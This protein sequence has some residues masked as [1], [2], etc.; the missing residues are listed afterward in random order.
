MWILPFSLIAIPV[1]LAIPLSAYLAWIMGGHYRPKGF[2]RWCEDR[3][4]SG[5]QNWKQYAVSLLAFNLVLYVF[6]FLILILQP[7]MPLNPRGLGAL[8]PSTIL[9]TVMS[10]ITN[11][12]I[13][14]YSGDVAF[15]N[16][17]QL[18][19]CLPMFFLSASVGFCALTAMIRA[20]RSDPDVGNF[21]LDM[22]R[23]VFY[24]FLPIAFVLS[25][26]YL[27]SGMPMTYQSDY[28]V[29]TLEPTAMGTT[30]SGQPKQQTIVVGPLAAFVPMKM[31]G[32]NGGGFYGMNSAHPF[33]NPSAF[34]N[35]LTTSSMMLFP[36]ALVFMYGRMLRRQRHG[37]VIFSVMLVLLVGTVLWAIHFDTLK[38][39]PGLSADPIARTFEIPS[40]SAPGGKRVIS[41]PAVAGLPVD[42][43]LGN[44]EGKELRFGTSAGSTFAAATVD[45]TCGA[46]NCEHDS[47]N[48]V[49]AV[50]PFFGM[51]VNCIFGGKGVGMINFLL[52]LIIGIF[53]VGQMV[54]RT[55]E[56]L[57]K[58]IGARE[59][60][61]AMIAL[62]IH[63]LVILGPSGLFAATNWGIK[64]ESNPGAHGFSQ[65]VY[66]F[67]SDSAN[68]GS[69]FDGLGTTYGLNNN[70]NPAPEAVPW[71][72]AATLVIM[73]GRFIPI[74]APIA[75]AGFLGM[76]KSTP[77]GLG[78]LRDDT[79][80][81]GCLLFGTIVIVGALLF[82]PVAALGPLAEHLGPIPFGG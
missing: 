16:F 1:V 73:L 43:H 66:Q 78:T 2:L 27:A 79:F 70:S 45:F 9:N 39:N 7:A 69:A 15:S 64:A 14:H 67:S 62:L 80:T 42:Q 36:M 32:T 33:E 35:L 8:A 52:F 60:K 38:P 29:N 30:D 49:A 44:L 17:T 18:F 46:V 25:L 47:L 6:G 81:F 11:T 19:F 31:L 12:D 23:V 59:V 71:D 55:P 54:G 40:A 21:F 51:W 58:K 74:I 24:T 77:F 13:Q 56:Y 72:V 53:V 22:W 75:L 68:N 26:F 48:P 63:P 50:A 3:V 76:K 28:Q 4:S 5:P 37:A 57:G 34:G 20:F 10:F 65:I 82:L 41:L 61:L